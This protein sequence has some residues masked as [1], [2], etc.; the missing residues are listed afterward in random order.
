MELDDK[1]IESAA[2]LSTSVQLTFGANCTIRSF[3]ANTISGKHG[4]MFG[5]ACQHLDTKS[6]RFVGTI[7]AGVALGIGGLCPCKTCLC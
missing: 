1:G 7:N 5:S 4:L 2:I 3:T 6:F